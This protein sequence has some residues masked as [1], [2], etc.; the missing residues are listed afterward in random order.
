MHPDTHCVDASAQVI[1]TFEAE[2]RY[3]GNTGS[4]FTFKS[5]LNAPNYKLIRGDLSTDAVGW[6]QPAL[7]Q[8]T[9]FS[10]GFVVR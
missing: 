10:F 4:V 8:S 7:P 3:I 9:P 6:Q 1:D 2:Y 5:N